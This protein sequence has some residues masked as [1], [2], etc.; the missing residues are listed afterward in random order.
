MQ[1]KTIDSKSISLIYFLH[2]KMPRSQ[3]ATYVTPF[4]EKQIQR[5]MRFNFKESLATITERFQEK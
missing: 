4:Q 5:L 2:Y 1:I 3:D